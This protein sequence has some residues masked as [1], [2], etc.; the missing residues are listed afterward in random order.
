MKS[1]MI[2]MAMFISLSFDANSRPI[3]CPNWPKETVLQPGQSLSV[4]N[5]SGTMLIKFVSSLKRRYSWNGVNRTINL[6]PRKERW[7]GALGIYSPEP[8][9]F[10]F[11]KGDGVSRILAQ[12]AELDFKSETDFLKWRNEEWNRQRINVIYNDS[13]IAAGWCKS[14]SRSQLNV[15]VWKILINGK[16]PRHLSGANNSAI[17]LK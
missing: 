13:G 9:L 15:D 12:E 11:W 17:I 6:I 8:L 5:K 7:Y 3:E 14:P 10:S 16:V 1:L 4:T 2:L